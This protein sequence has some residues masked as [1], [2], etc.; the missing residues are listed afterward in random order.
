M[1]K[2]KGNQEKI[3]KKTGPATVSHPDTQTGMFGRTYILHFQRMRTHHRPLGI[4]LTGAERGLSTVGGSDLQLVF[5]D[6]F[7]VELFPI[8]DDAALLV[9]AG[10]RY[11][12]R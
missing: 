8:A 9:D 1:F 10:K 12:Y 11:M 3:I 5:F 6:V 7:A 2:N 4:I